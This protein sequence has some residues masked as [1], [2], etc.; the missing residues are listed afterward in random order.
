MEREVA[1][2]LTRS[3]KSPGTMDI[4]TRK[5]AKAQGLKKYFTGNPCKNGHTAERQ[6]S[7]GICIACSNIKQKEKY[8][9]DPEKARARVRKYYAENSEACV[10][11]AISHVNRVRHTP[12]YKAKNAIWQKNY[13]E[14]NPESQTWA[15]A[16]EHRKMTVILRT[17][18]KRCVI[19]GTGRQIRELVGCSVEEVRAH[20][21]AQFSPGMTWDNY[22]DWHVDHIRPCASFENPADP[23]CW[24][25]SNLQPLWAE[26]NLRKSDKWEAA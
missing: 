10:A 21:E 15:G 1:A 5:E 7:N 16:S 26:D 24:H 14:T 22:G 19:N 6:T 11:R 20:L 23:E 2:S 18:F 13:R 12:E 8:E 4:I 25:F 9:A 3:L 17:R